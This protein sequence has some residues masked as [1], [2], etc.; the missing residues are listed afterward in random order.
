[1]F[2]LVFDIQQNLYRGVGA[3]KLQQDNIPVFQELGNY[4]AP[5]AV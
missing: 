1:M 3:H 4:H 2:S 5:E